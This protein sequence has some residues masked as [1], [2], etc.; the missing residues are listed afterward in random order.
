MGQLKYYNSAIADWEPVVVGAV[1]PTGPAGASITLR[2]EVA[3][4]ADLPGSGNTANDAYVVT[5]DGNLWVW[6]G[7]A[8]FDAGQIVG[9]QGPQGEAGPTGAQGAQGETGP[10]GPQ[11]LQG[12]AGPT[13]A[14]GLQGDAG[15]TGPQGDAGPTG[16]QGD[17][18][19]TGAQGL[20]GDTGPT[21]AQ[22][23]IGAT[24]DVGP[25]GAQGDTGPTGAQGDA[26]PTG[27]TGAAG[28]SYDQNLDTTSAVSFA[29]VTANVIKIE[30]G[31]Q[32][33]FQA[34]TGATG[35]ITHDCSAG[36][37]FYH[38]SPAANFTA[39]FV[40]LNLASGYGTTVTLVIAQGASAYIPSAVQIGGVSQTIRWQG[41]SIPV[42]TA[43]R[44]DVV[45]FSIINNGGT[46]VV[47]GQLT[48]F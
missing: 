37:I 2:G 30:D 41:N 47:L 38:T 32:E 28:A 39:N 8:W 16:P 18:G 12:E 29:S 24:G 40:N 3:T 43:S 21:G 33:K 20:Q 34:L 44:T 6:N 42:G 48:G 25:T 23:D 46:Y 19:P 7:T 10:T 4:A 5:A 45:A 9:P 26:G 31:A 35:T 13:G 11:G 14:Q 22:G 17:V 36:Q 15:P 1:G 27:P